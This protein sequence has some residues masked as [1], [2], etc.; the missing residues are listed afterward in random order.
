MLR[1]VRLSGEI[2]LSLDKKVFSGQIGL[3]RGQYFSL[4]DFVM[5]KD[6][7]QPN[8][9]PID[10]YGSRIFRR[11]TVHRKKNLTEPNRT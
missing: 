5:K 10:A 7:D 1:D 11:G 8:Q 6:R 4:M 9:L 3:P 2:F